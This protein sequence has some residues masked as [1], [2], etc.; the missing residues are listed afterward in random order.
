MERWILLLL[1]FSAIVFALI[2]VYFLAA[3][4]R[5][6][7]SL[8]IALNDA[9]ARTDVRA[10]YGGMVLGTALFFGWCALATARYQAGLVCLVLIYGGLAL[11]RGLAIAVGQ[12]PA[13]MMWVFLLIEVVVALASVGL[14][15]SLD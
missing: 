14:L 6:A 15:R 10:T 13:T 8:G 11:G 1:W 7:A 5:A 4:E 9:T 12:R 2:G 3:P